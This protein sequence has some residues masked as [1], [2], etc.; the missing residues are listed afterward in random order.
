[1][2]HK[3][4]DWPEWLALAE[5]AVNNKTHTATKVLLVVATTYHND[6]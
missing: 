5:Y 1:V 4:K 2:D 6:K 3:Q